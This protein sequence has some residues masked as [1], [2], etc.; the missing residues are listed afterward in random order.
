[1][2]KKKTSTV[3]KVMLSFLALVIGV[4]G[5]FYLF[6]YFTLPLTDEVSVTDEVYYSNDPSSDGNV[7]VDISSYGA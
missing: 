4:V 6:N 2:A 5:S 3:N 1:M 7:S